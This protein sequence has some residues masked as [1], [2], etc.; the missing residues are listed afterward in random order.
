MYKAFFTA[1]EKGECGDLVF[2]PH[3]MLLNAQCL[4]YAKINELNIDISNFKNL[5]VLCFVETWCTD[6]S[7][8]SLVLDGFTLATSYCRSEFKGGG[9]SIYTRSSLSFSKISLKKFC[10]EKHIEVC[11]LTYKCGRDTEI[12]I[13]ACYRSPTGNVDVFFNAIIDV[14]D[15]LYKP[16]RDV[17]L[18]GDFNFNS[19][20]NSEDFKKFCDVLSNFNLVPRVGWPTRVSGTSVST[21]DHI[22]VNSNDN[23]FACVL[24]N[25]VSDHRSIFYEL[26][27]AERVN[28]NT[29]CWRRFFSDETIMNFQRDL[30]NENWNKLYMEYNLNSAFELFYNIFIY[31]FNVNFP[32]KK[33]YIDKN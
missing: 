4:N 2:D 8:D 24:D 22:F 15:F 11:G 3:I 19:Y 18:C 14:L 30:S 5:N 17:F 26:N 27:V 13:L 9:I 29:S 21:L 23:G 7:V 32:L 25:N 16:G 31:H 20:N 28:L 6:E 33:L 12:L 1:K 10:F